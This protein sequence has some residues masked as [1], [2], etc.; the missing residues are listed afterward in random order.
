MTL[1]AFIYGTLIA[2]FLGSAFHLWKG[3][4]FGRII[5]YNIISFL[6]FWG[7][8]FVGGWTNFS[9][10]II[11]PIRLGTAI[12]GSIIILLFGHWLGLINRES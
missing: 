12:L 3:G 11:G 6:G 7:G 2:L 9:F 1:P 10:W 8:H 4:S 5:L